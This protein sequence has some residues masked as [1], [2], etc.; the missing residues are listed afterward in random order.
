VLPA[1]DGE[2]FLRFQSEDPLTNQRVVHGTL[3]QFRSVEQILEVKI[4]LES[5][6]LHFIEDSLFVTGPQTST[7]E[8]INRAHTQI[9]NVMRLLSVLHGERFDAEVLS[10]LDGKGV[11]L[12][13]LPARSGPRFQATFYSLSTLSD[14]IQKCVAWSETMDERAGRAILYFEHACLLKEHADTMPSTSWNAAFSR[15]MAFLQLFKALTALIGDPQVDRDYQVRCQRIG[16]PKNYWRER[17]KP[18]YLIRSDRDVAHHSHMPHQT[19][20]FLD[21][22]S[23]ALQVLQEVLESHMGSTAAARAGA[24]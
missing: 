1:V 14:R 22:F 6:Q 17:V 18:L 8:S 23:K 4:A 16:L 10:V 7:P 11:P 3:S 15:S 5:L 13:T 21:H 12:P 20:E 9:E 19:A 24:A 2:Y